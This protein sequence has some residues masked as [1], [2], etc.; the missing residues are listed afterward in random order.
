[1][2]GTRARRD[3]A[4]SGES[5]DSSPCQQEIDSPCALIMAPSA[6]LRQPACEMARRPPRQR[7]RVRGAAGGGELLKDFSDH[8][9]GDAF[10]LKITLGEALP[11]FV[12]AAR[13]GALE[14]QRLH[15]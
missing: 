10:E 13:A 7:G 14:S 3:R 1:M 15:H 5:A 8:L 2:R 11:E 12:Q 4:P 9:A 6:A